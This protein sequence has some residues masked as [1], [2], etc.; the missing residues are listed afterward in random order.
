LRILLNKAGIVLLM[1]CLLS[2]SGCT[3]ISGTSNNSFQNQPNK[4]STYYLEKM[5]KAYG[6]EKV[7]WQ[8]MAIQML[9]RE[10]K[11]EDAEKLMSELP[12]R[13]QIKRTQSREIAL[14]K[15]E[16]DIANQ[17]YTE[18]EKQLK[19]LNKRLYTGHQKDRY[20]QAQIA[21]VNA[22]K[23]DDRLDLL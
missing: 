3:Q 2:L 5:K 6:R 9:I 15:I 7:D 14:L 10:Q 21:I 22:K 13:E 16:L 17:K 11:I 18:A 4:S 19:R 20:Y 23:T 1:A 12:E 8:L